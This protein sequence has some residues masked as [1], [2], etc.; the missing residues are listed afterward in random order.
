M[1]IDQLLK[2]AVDQNASDLHLQ[3][4]ALPLVR[5]LGQMRAVE[6]PPLTDSQ[7]RQFI[8]AIAP[9]TVIDDIDSAMA[10]GADFSYGAASQAR[11]RCNLYSHLGSPGIVLRVIMPRIRTVEELHLPPILRE[12]ALARRG[13]TL[14]SGATG[15]GKSTTLAALVDLLNE[16]YYL[17]ILT[18]EDPV[19]YEH[20]NKRSLVT[21]VEVGRDTPSFEHG[22]RQ[23]MRQAPD[24]ILVGELRDA[25]SVRMALRAADTGHQVLA[26]IHS[27]NAAQT[28][29][30]LLAMVPVTELSTARQQLAVAWWASLRSGSPS[31]AAAEPLAGRRDPPRRFRR[32]QIHP[33]GPD[34][35]RRRLYRHRPV[36]NADV[37]HA[38][39]SAL[40]RGNHQRHPGSE[41]CH[42]RRG[43]RPRDARPG[44]NQAGLSGAGSA[45]ILRRDLLWKGHMPDGPEKEC[46]GIL[47]ERLG[48][49]MATC[50]GRLVTVDE[51]VQAIREAARGKRWTWVENWVAE[52]GP[53]YVND[54]DTLV[55]DFPPADLARVKSLEF[56]QMVWR[57]QPSVFEYQ[58][59]SG[60]CFVR[61]W[62]DRNR[63]RSKTTSKLGEGPHDG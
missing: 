58:E 36:G 7:V 57:L 55:F 11:F 28:I 40:Y 21:H 30:R 3:T 44:T 20:S 23:A 16:A 45:V 9:R 17:K 42:Q 34:Q 33:R 51:I 38:P 26:T 32:L 43:A 61:M 62:W 19:E 27:S 56:T 50:G 63:F 41:R 37:R 4:G 39:A 12:I 59:W 35:G 1:T 24:V 14:M 13:L 48:W 5:I 31:A 47:D 46:R 8:Q 60:R 29:E 18:I 15:S 52:E 49:L 6:V 53:K 10:R 54:M 2:F 22:L 25:E